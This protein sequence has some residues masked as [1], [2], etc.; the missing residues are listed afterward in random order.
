VGVVLCHSAARIFYR[1]A[2]NSGLPVFEL[3][4][5]VEKLRMGDQVRVD[6]KKGLIT[7]LTTSETIQVKPLPDFIMAILDAG[8]INQY[9]VG[10]KSEYKLLK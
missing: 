2:L 6:I 3:G 9:I 1:N 7:N 10:R 8:S 4:D 5:E